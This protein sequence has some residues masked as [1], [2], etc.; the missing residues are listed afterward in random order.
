MTD[1]PGDDLTLRGDVSPSGGSD[2]HHIDI[3]RAETQFNELYRALSARSQGDDAEDHS[4]NEK[5]VEKDAEAPFDLREYLSS[6]NDAHQR[7]GIAHKHVG[8]TWDNLRVEVAGGVDHKVRTC[9]HTF[10]RAAQ[11]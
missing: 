8:V 9:Q 4:A 2:S 7:A 10:W 6:S 5:D 11:S 1:T 3:V